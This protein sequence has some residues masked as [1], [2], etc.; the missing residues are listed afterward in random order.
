[1]DLGLGAGLANGLEIYSPVDPAGRFDSTTPNWI[2][3][4]TVWE[5]N[6]V[7]LDILKSRA[8]LL[9]ARTVAMR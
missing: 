4:L 1:M 7:V 3:G 9:A 5:A 8:A 2:T 6:P